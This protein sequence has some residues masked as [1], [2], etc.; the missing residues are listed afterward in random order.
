MMHTALIALRVHNIKL[1]T[2]QRRLAFSLH[3]DETLVEKSVPSGDKYVFA[4]RMGVH[5]AIA[6][7]RQSIRCG[8]NGSKGWPP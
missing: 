7:D 5:S 8:D 3:K 6:I 1:G 2:I 4:G